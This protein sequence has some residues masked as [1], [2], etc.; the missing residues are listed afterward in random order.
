MKPD[1]N[2]ENFTKYI[3]E[4][5]DIDGPSKDFVNK[6]MKSVRLESEVSSIRVYKPLI[7][8]TAWAVIIAVFVISC[9][10]VLMGP[11]GDSTIFSKINITFLEKLPSV[12]LF[13]NIHFSNT[14]TL[15]FMFFS[16]LVLF[17]LYTI[18]NYF[19]RQYNI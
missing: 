19:N 14:F 3:I 11:S 5:A 18:K 10:F 15:S 8:K 1:K 9:I 4:E 12:N 2:I 13:D 16:I 7:S 6:V 17:Q